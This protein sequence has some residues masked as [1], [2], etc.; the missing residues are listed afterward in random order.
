MNAVDGGSEAAGG[1]AAPPDPCSSV[2]VPPRPA[3]AAGPDTTSIVFALTAIDFGLALDAGVTGPYGFNLDK[4]C[5][6]PGPGTCVLPDAAKVCDVGSRGVDNNGNRVFRLAAQFKFVQQDELNLA[7]S[8]GMSGVLIRVDN[9]NGKSDDSQA[10]LA[11][12]SSLGLE[13]LFDGGVPQLN[14]Q[15]RWTVEDQSVIGGVISDAG[16]KPRF[17]DETAWVSNNQVVGSLDFPITIGSSLN[18]PVTIDLTGG[19]IV[20]TL[21]MKN[22]LRTLSGTFSGRWEAKKMLLSFQNYTDPLDTTKHVCGTDPTYQDLK[23]VTCSTVDIARV[24]NL[25]NQGSDCDA[26][27]VGIHFEAVEAQLGNVSARPD[28]GFPCG[29]DWAPSCAP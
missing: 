9:Y 26:L 12:F 8:T 29:A 7:I 2:G 14:G 17:S 22:G 11:V 24:Q 19:V 21:G 15:D 25:D 16:A 23:L 10:R 27:S 28:A 20:G 6:C 18:A 3:G 1:D 4:T 13:G 5:T